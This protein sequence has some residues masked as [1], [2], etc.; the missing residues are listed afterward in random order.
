MLKF[1]ENGKFRIMQI[2]DI[3]DTANVSPDTI[4]LIS[5]AIESEKP[6]LVIFSG[7]QIYGLAPSFIGNSYEKVKNSINTI[8]KPVVDAGIAFTYVYGNHDDNRFALSKEE[9]FKIYKDNPL[10]LAFNADDNI[11]G[12]CNH[13]LLVKDRNG[14][15]CMNIYLID[16]LS[17]DIGGDSPPVSESQ[18]EWYRKTR[19]KLYADNK[20]YIPSI[21]FQHIPVP[22]VYNLLIKNDKKTA[23]YVRGYDQYA[24][25]YT[26]DKDNCRNYEKSF[27]GESPAVPFKNGGEFDAF[28]ECGDVFSVYYGHDHANSFVGRYQGIDL[29]YTQGVGFNTYGPAYKRGV[30]VFEFD[31]KNPA[32]YETYTVTAEDFPDFEVSDKLKFTFMNNAPTSAKQVIPKIEIGLAVI[33]VTSVSIAI[34]KKFKK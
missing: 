8:L 31:E 2:A 16:S 5:R 24:G 22:E 28:K 29:G 15:D 9:Q 26:I 11:E 25:Y 34:Y 21:V 3:Q 14:K 32:E 20:K 18:I 1:N 6:D 27:I 13:N 17:M 19:D 7:D 30:R 33:A 4:N 12:Y 23:G 10:C